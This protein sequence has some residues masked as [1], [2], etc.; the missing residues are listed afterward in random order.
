MGLNL[1]EEKLM[2]HFATIGRNLEKA[3][4]T[5]YT[6]MSRKDDIHPKRFR[7]EELKSGP[8]KGF[9]IDE[10][11]YNEMLNK[12]YELWGWDKKTGMQTETGL[13]KLGLG[14]IAEKLAKH[15]NL[16]DK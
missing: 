11:R 16:I 2:E 10:N 4:N 7:E 1:N 6:N 12:F 15:G 9:K 3:F 14:N 8:Y 13:E 5:L